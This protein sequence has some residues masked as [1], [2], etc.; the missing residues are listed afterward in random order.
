MYT[1]SNNRYFRL[2]FQRNHR[3]NPPEQ[4][5]GTTSATHLQDGDRGLPR[6]IDARE[7]EINVR[8]KPL[9]IFGDGKTKE[10]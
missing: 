2:I 4:S 1:I 9:G 5:V 3:G 7:V 8:G 10:R 6:N